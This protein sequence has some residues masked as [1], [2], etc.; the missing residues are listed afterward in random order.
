M[1]D[2]TLVL[3]SFLVL[4][5]MV[6]AYVLFKVLRSSAKVSGPLGSFNV[7]LGGAFGGYFALTVFIATFYAHSLKAT[8]EPTVEEWKVTGS[9]EFEP[10]EEPDLAQIYCRLAPSLT[11]DPGNRFE[12]RIPVIKGGDMPRII[13]KPKGYEGDTLY[14]SKAINALNPPK[15]NFDINA[16][17]RIIEFAPIK[18]RR[19]MATAK[20]SPTA[21]VTTANGG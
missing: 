7:A 5:P 4:L 2:N 17:Q 6:P 13:V 9:F 1:A 3:L 18:F 20:A 14:L 11:V 8:A 16:D 10:G 19:V 15:H 12:W 21:P